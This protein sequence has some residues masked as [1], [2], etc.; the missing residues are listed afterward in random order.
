MET[1]EFIIYVSNQMRSAEFYEKLLTITPSLNVPGMTAFDLSKNVRLGLMPEKGIA[2]IIAPVMP[3]PET[4]NGIP[5]CE[6]YL[7]VT[8]PEAYIN[9]ALVLGGKMIS[10][11]QL[12]NWGDSVGYVSDLDGHIIAFAKTTVVNG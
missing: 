10:P 11:L 9:R 12:R 7:K 3:H 8:N 4:G 1:V 2:K 6:I 5:R